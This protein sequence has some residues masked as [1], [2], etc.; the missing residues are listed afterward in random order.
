MHIAKSRLPLFATALFAFAANMAV[1]DDSEIFLGS[2]NTGVA[3]NVLF[4]LDTSGSMST[5][6]VDTQPYDATVTYPG[7]C[8]SSKIYYVSGAATTPP[9]CSGGRAA[10]SFNATL[11]HCAAGLPDLATGGTGGGFYQD[12]LVQYVQTSSRRG[13]TWAWSATLGGS[14]GSDVSC[15]TDYPATAPYPTTTSSASSTPQYTPTAASSYWAS[16]VSVKTSYTLYSANYLNYWNDPARTTVLGTRISVVQQAATNLINS[17]TNVNVGLMRY[18]DNSGS[19]DTAAKGGMVT[20]PMSPVETNRAAI[21]ATIN[22]YGANGW[23]PLSETLFEA[24]RYY[25]GGQV[26]FGNTSTINSGGTVFRSVPGSR[27]GGVASSNQYAT[28]ITSACQKNFVIFLTDGLPTQDNEA[29]TL[30]N[31]LPNAATLGGACD[32]T[33]LAPYSTLPGGWGPSATAGQCLGKLAQFMNKADLNSSL[34]DQQSVQTYFIGFGDDPNLAQAFTYLDAAATRGGGKAYTAGDLT[35]LQAVL[36]NIISEIRITSNSFSAP[37]VAVNAFNRTE[38]LN[39]LYVAVFQPSASYHWP[40]NVKKYKFVNGAV[41]DANGNDAIDPATGFFKGNA[42]VPAT[43]A[44]S[45]WSAAPDGATVPVGGAASHI[46][47]WDPSSTPT[48]TVYTYKGASNA[49][50]NG[51]ALLPFIPANIT[52]AD[53]GAATTADRDEIVSFARGQDPLNPTASRLAMGDPLH[54]QPAV[55]IYG[56]TAAS[57]DVNDAVVY[58]ATNDGYLHAFDVTSGVELWSFIP[59]DQLTSLDDLLADSS[60][61][62]KHYGLDGTIRVLKYDENGDGIVAGNDRVL[63][64]FGE[65]RGGSNYYAIDVTHKTNPLFVWTIG[66]AQLPAL[67]QAWSTPVLTKVNVSGATQNSQKIA[68]VIGGGYDPLE[69]NGIYNAARAVRLGAVVGKCRRRHAQPAAYGSRDSERCCR[70]RHEWRRFRRSA[71]CRRYGWAALAFRY[72]QWQY[73]GE[74]RHRR[75]HRLARCARRQ[76]GD[77]GE[78]SPVLQCAGSGAHSKARPTPVHERCDRLGLSRPSAHHG[79]ARSLLF[80]A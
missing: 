12:N 71:L 53:L 15:S 37:T 75:R 60:S 67:G 24:Y 80:R 59:Q 29:D 16:R 52:L 42:T 7:A 32:N 45:F 69:E 40:G 28:P 5:P 56:G 1:A 25:S 35:S 48:R 58:A 74:S 43:A 33:A 54:S 14:S 55:V 65:G 49:S 10:A 21:T 57:P 79:H 63:L 20:F 27:V 13:G 19:G 77:R 22:S 34:A 46:P 50:P 23:T 17:L 2:S 26:L 39:D 36:S 31:S 47:D 64:Y 6:V 38:T 68:M 41:V 62:S 9:V 61:S 78:H 44:Q 3:P 11:L 66:T 18:S 51:A 30:I 76:P 4:I 72:L 70:H 8:N 73:G